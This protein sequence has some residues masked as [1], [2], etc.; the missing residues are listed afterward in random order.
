MCHDPHIFQ[1]EKE[2]KQ[3]TKEAKE[4]EQWAEVARKGATM[5]DLEEFQAQQVA[6]L[7]VDVAPSV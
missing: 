1:A 2:R 4:K 3:V 7:K 5:R 6:N